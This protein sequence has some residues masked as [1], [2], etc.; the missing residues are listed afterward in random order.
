MVR[1]RSV[2]EG[3]RPAE[4]SGTQKA[5]YKGKSAAAGA[6]AGWA[7]QRQGCLPGMACHAPTEK[8]EAE[9]GK[10][11]GSGA[12]AS[13]R[14]PQK[15]RLEAGATKAKNRKEIRRPHPHALRENGA[16]RKTFSCVTAV[17]PAR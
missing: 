12:G 10:P 7:A 6:I 1:L 13:S 4:S 9:R 8:W 2:Q 3:G 14:T 5:R 11:R 15:S 16:P 17:P